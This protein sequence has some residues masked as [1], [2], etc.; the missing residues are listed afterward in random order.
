MIIHRST[1]A[2]VAGQ[3]FQIADRTERTH[4]CAASAYHRSGIGV[5]SDDGDRFDLRF[6]ERKEVAVVLEENH[7]G[8][9]GLERDPS[10]LFVV[11]RHGQVSLLAIEPAEANGGRREAADL[12]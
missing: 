11:E 10:T 9:R 1:A 6:V 7:A 12:V 3:A 2:E 8:A 4:S 5:R